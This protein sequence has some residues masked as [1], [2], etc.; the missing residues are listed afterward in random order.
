MASI[1]EATVLSFF[2]MFGEVILPDS[3]PQDA[4]I[5]DACQRRDDD[6]L[7][8]ILSSLLCALL[9]KQSSN[10]PSSFIQRH[11]APELRRRR[12]RYSGAFP[13]SFEIESWTP[14]ECTEILCNLCDFAAEESSEIRDH[15]DR[16]EALGHNDTGESYWYF[17][18]YHIYSLCAKTASWTCVCSTSESMNQLADQLTLRKRTGSAS[19]ELGEH[20]RDVL[21]PELTRRE[22]NQLKAAARLARM[23]LAQPTFFIPS[24]RPRRAGLNFVRS[25]RFRL[26][27]LN[28]QYSISVSKRQVHIRKW[29]RGGRNAD[30]RCVR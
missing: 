2:R 17:S 13:S 6:A 19:L 18:G 25:F 28:A 7:V 29:F 22:T 30:G 8:T 26:H 4:V 16:S 1:G 20:I 9:G 12:T 10:N 27:I 23:G 5:S 21:L 24:E 3:V 11:L 14:E 15:A